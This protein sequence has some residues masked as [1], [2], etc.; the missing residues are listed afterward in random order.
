MVTGSA[1]G[2]RLDPAAL[3][4]R[5]MTSAAQPRAPADAIAASSLLNG[6]PR[7]EFGIGAHRSGFLPGAR[8]VRRM[9]KPL[10]LAREGRL[11]SETNHALTPLEAYGGRH[12]RLCLFETA[13]VMGA[14]E[15][16]HI[17][18]RPKSALLHAGIGDAQL[19]LL[20]EDAAKVDLFLPRRMLRRGGLWLRFRLA[21]V[22]A[23]M[24][25]DE[26]GER[27]ARKGLGKSRP[28]SLA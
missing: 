28:S 20:S 12:R 17:L 9:R 14:I 8:V 21:P 22:R 16:D 1:R 23:D 11:I 18:A 13:A 24:G 15:V 6:A 19:E 3:A 10:R 2:D 4:P 27:R 25:L 7:L 26:P 5:H